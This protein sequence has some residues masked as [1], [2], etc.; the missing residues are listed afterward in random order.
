MKPCSNRFVF[1]FTAVFFLLPTFAVQ[2]LQEARI[3]TVDERI[4]FYSKK[5]E[6]HPTLFAVYPLLAA[7]YLDKARATNDMKW[8]QLAETNLKKSH[9]LQPN[10]EASKIYTALYAYRH[11]FMEARQWGERAA[12]ANPEDTQVKA[13]LVEADLGLGEMDQAIK[14][15]PPLDSIPRDF[16]TAVAMANV[17]KEK[18][19]YT[20]ARELYLKAEKFALEQ[21]VTYLAVWARTNAAG[22][23]IDAK[24]AVQ[25]LPDLEAATKMQKDNLELRRHWAEYYAAQGETAKALEII[26]ALLKELP[27]PAYHHQAYLLAQ[28][29]GDRKSSRRHFTA[30]EKGYRAPIKAEEIFT[31]GSLAQLYCDAGT[32]LDEAQALARRNLEYKRDKEATDTL[33]CV[34]NKI[35]KKKEE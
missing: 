34:E 33:A 22:M 18:Q 11:R 19:H 26:E 20:Q 15:L 16:Y 8:L 29:L 23:L 32:R 30:A 1:A 7:A 13:L 35:N 3:P 21:N 31:L 12:P 6:K 2:G 27:H 9:N 28:K 10:F 4:D 25:A 17:L 14:R 5:L 24:Q